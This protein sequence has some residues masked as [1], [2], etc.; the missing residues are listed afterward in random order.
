MA[1][2]LAATLLPVPG[3]AGR[4]HLSPCPGR[5]GGLADVHRDLAAI[6]AAGAVRLV[7][8]VE[9]HEL[10]VPLDVWRNAVAAADLLWHH[11]PITDW[12]VPNAAFEV[13]WEA[14]G[15][16]DRLRDGETIAIHCRAGIGRTGTIAARLLVETA[17][18]D[19][20]EAIA[21]VRTRH[22]ATAVETSAQ[23]AH[24]GD[25]ARR[26]GRDA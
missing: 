23:A 9:A 1:N 22:V 7:T 12:G 21:W 13:Q 10:P 14:T 5:H 26:L 19:P 8:L 25:V 18:L 6:R 3:L 17:G 20:R 15:L 16:A 11:L 4:L 24:L 2:D